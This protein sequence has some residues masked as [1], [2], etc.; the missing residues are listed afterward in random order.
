[1]IVRRSTLK[2]H[3]MAAH[4]NSFK[5]DEIYVEELDLEDNLLSD[6]EM[7]FPK[8]LVDLC[9]GDVP[10]MC[11]FKFKPFLDV[12]IEYIDGWTRRHLGIDGAFKNP[13]ITDETIY[14]NRFDVVIKEYQVQHPK[15]DDICRFIVFRRPIDALVLELDV[16]KSGIRGRRND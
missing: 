5:S 4:L 11:S 12:R 1:M 3:P 6:W 10:W 16:R 15:L 7:K 14:L 13:P 9:K 8:K 2:T